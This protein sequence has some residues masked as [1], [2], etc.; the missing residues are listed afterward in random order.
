M[1]VLY[2]FNLFFLLSFVICSCTNNESSLTLKDSKIPTYNKIAKEQQIKDRLAQEKEMT[3]DPVTGVVPRNNKK[4]C[5]RSLKFLMLF[6]M[7]E[8]QII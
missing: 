3:M 4:K 7:S 5:S 1:R 6:G 8:D 2:Y